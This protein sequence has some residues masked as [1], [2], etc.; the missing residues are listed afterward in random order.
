MSDKP[1]NNNNT[2]TAVYQPVF[3]AP[4]C[5]DHRRNGGSCLD[6]DPDY[7]VWLNRVHEIDAYDFEAWVSEWDYWAS[8][9]VFMMGGGV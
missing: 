4:C 1:I 9:R 3:V 5:E 7:P 8:E 6:N 2:K